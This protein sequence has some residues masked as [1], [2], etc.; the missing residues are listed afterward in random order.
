MA[1]NAHSPAIDLKFKEMSLTHYLK[2]FRLHLQEDWLKVPATTKGDVTSFEAMRK[3]LERKG[4]AANVSDAMKF[5]QDRV[6]TTGVSMKAPS[7]VFDGQ[8]LKTA[9]L[10]HLPA[11]RTK[12]LTDRSGLLV[13]I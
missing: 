4:A 7:C 12:G 10:I 1:I 5:L 2:E 3:A 6:P 8:A 13:E 9:R 11:F